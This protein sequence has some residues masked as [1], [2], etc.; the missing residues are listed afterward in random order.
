MITKIEKEI[1][2]WL[3]FL[4]AEQVINF[5]HEK[6]IFKPIAK[7]VEEEMENIREPLEDAE[8]EVDCLEDEIDEKESEIEKLERKIKRLQ[9]IRKLSRQKLL[10]STSAAGTHSLKD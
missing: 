1:R 2:V 4:E 7:L 3:T 9:L 10:S 6:K 5:L 8:N